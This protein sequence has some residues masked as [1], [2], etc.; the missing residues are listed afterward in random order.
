M[1]YCD[2][3]PTVLAYERLKQGKF[4]SSSRISAFL[5]TVNTFNVSIVHKAGKDIILTDYISRHPPE[6]DTKRCQVCDFVEEQVLVGDS[7][8]RKVSVADVLEG[9]YQMPY[10]QPNTWLKL[11]KKDQTLSKLN[12][13]IS[14][15]Q[16]P[17]PKRT[18]ERTQ[19][20]KLYTTS[21]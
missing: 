9:K 3:L 19:P 7:I 11:Q 2:N 10:L 5:T 8:V 21:L 13:L 15:G 14:V 1:H 12:K 17:E 16:K 6:C 18:G 4:S 20:S